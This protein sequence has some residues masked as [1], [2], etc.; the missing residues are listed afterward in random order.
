MDPF[1]SATTDEIIT[2]LKKVKLWDGNLATK[3][4]GLDAEL[5]VEDLS[6]GQRQLF[7]FARAV[8]RKKEGWMLVLDEPTS[9]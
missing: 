1:S 6:H 2:A 4:G 7:C 9:S 3:E 5:K 8:L